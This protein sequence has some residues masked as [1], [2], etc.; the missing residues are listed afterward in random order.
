MDSHQERE[1]PTRVFFVVHPLTMMRLTPRVTRSSPGSAAGCLFF[2]CSARRKS[3]EEE[4]PD[5]RRCH[6]WG[7]SHA[8][9]RTQSQSFAS[10]RL[11]AYQR[12]SL[13][14]NIVIC[15][16]LATRD[17]GQMK[18]KRR[19]RKKNIS[20][21]TGKKKIMKLLA[22]LLVAGL[23]SATGPRAGAVSRN[24]VLSTITAPPTNADPLFECAWRKLAYEYAQ[25]LQPFRPASTFSEIHDALQL[26]T[27]CN[28]VADCTI[29]SR[30]DF[31]FCALT[32]LSSLSPHHYLLSFFL[33]FFGPKSPFQPRCRQRPLRLESSPAPVPRP[34]GSTLTMPRAA[35]RPARAPYPPRSRRL[36]LASS[37][38]GACRAP[39]QCR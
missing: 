26:A 12:R 37:L 11:R 3:D 8:E 33:S 15:T 17:D 6:H 7:Q 32:L 23:A 13:T 39:R 35:T 30:M 20:S 31:T 24:K 5:G 36:L 19:E 18:T 22:L 14:R 21:I 25:K 2:N 16:R 10:W 38:R 29:H 34:P 28:Q 9:P 1:R 27:L 4:T